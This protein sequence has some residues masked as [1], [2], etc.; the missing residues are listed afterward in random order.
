MIIRIKKR[1]LV[2]LLVL[3]LIIPLVYAAQVTQTFYVLVT[4]G[5]RAPVIFYVNTTTIT[6]IAGT[7]V[8]ANVEFNVSDGDGFSDLEDG[9][10]QVNITYNGVTRTS[11]SCTPTDYNTNYTQ[12]KCSITIYYYDNTTSSWIINASVSDGTNTSINATQTATVNSLSAMSLTGN[13]TFSNVNLGE[14]NKAADS[15]LTL[16]NTGNFD[17]IQINVTAYNLTGITDSSYRIDARNF[18]VNTTNAVAG[19]GMPLQN[20]T[21]LNVSGATLPHLSQNGAA[22]ANETLYFWLDVPGSGEI[23]AQ[24]YN[25]TTWWAVIV[26]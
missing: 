3:L 11:S 12:Y 20:G 16:N 17:F 23:T 24:N 14:A 26:E 5:N 13:L 22:N 1:D 10:A 25:S 8:T 7:T 18:T 6:P 2:F 15:P 4:I 21:S 9:T 19:A